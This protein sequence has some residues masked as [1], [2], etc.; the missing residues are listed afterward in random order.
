MTDKKPEDHFPHLLK[1]AYGYVRVSSKRQEQ[2]NDSL[3]VQSARIRDY[4]FRQGFHLVGIYED[5]ASASDPEERR[6]GLAH[7]L[8]LA[9][10]G[11]AVLVVADASRLTRQSAEVSGILSAGVPVH[12]VKEGGLLGRRKLRALVKPAQLAIA[13]KSRAQRAAHARSRKTPGTYPGLT[14]EGRRQGHLSAGVRRD[15][16]IRRIAAHVMSMPDVLKMT[17]AGRAEHLNTHGIKNVTSRR[18]PEGKDWTVYT[19]SKRW[20]LVVAE[21]ALQEQDDP[22]V[23][24]NQPPVEGAP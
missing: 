5:T 15:D 6:D 2:T 14:P 22:F 19:V 23:P 9:R 1:R 7:A 20:P 3:D 17:M 8:R 16:V 18:V 4:A 12:S 21:I 11:K 10:A 13:R 24:G